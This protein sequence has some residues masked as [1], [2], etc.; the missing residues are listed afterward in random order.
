[1][2]Y[3][4]SV[5]PLFSEEPFRIIDHWADVLGPDL[6]RFMDL[7]VWNSSSCMVERFQSLAAENDDKTLSKIVMKFA[8]IRV[9][10]PQPSKM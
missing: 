9:L 2:Q 4:V 10:S 1:M 6:K 8:R 3:L 5:L 7:V